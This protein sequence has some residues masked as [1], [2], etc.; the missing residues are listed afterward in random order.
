MPRAGDCDVQV[1]HWRAVTSG[2]CSNIF[3]LTLGRRQTDW[4]SFAAFRSCLL[5]PS[6]DFLLRPTNSLTPSVKRLLMLQMRRFH[7]H[8]GLLFQSNYYE[9][10]ARSHKTSVTAGRPWWIEAPIFRRVGIINGLWTSCWLWLY[11]K[12]TVCV[13]VCRCPAENKPTHTEDYE[14]G[15]IICRSSTQMW[16]NTAELCGKLC[17]KKIII[18]K[19]FSFFWF[20]LFGERSSGRETQGHTVCLSGLFFTSN[21]KLISRS[22]G[23]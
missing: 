5:L 14:A 4:E 13:R 19:I 21:T 15:K 16:V 10:F 7:V 17:K 8:A 23:W 9:A 20:V 1:H 12:E 11:S 18:I 22:L 2:S 6:S 3:E